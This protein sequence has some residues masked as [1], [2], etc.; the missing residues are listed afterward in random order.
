M[1]GSLVA[2]VS[3]VG[4]RDDLMKDIGQVS[5]TLVYDNFDNFSRRFLAHLFPT[6]ASVTFE[7]SSFSFPHAQ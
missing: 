2:S 1:C 6:K 5:E 7:I 3:M 4:M